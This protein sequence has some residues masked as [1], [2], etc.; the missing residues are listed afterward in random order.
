MG[1]RRLPVNG[2]LSSAMAQS[3]CKMFTMFVYGTLQKG[4]PNH[5][6]M[7]DTK[8]GVAK[9]KGR[10]LTAKKYPLV[11]ASD[12]NIPF[13]LF[14]EGHGKNIQGEIY[15]VDEQMLATLDELEGHPI[16]Y[17]RDLTPIDVTQSDNQLSAQTDCW[18]YFLKKYKPKMLDLPYLDRYDSQGDHG[19]KYVES[20]DLSDPECI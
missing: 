12:F 4:Q 14:K 2:L 17:E 15:E 13:L 20:E 8:N 11:I 3:T 10:G 9:Y 18:C 6:V 5:A 1:Y 16:F 7:S 19:L